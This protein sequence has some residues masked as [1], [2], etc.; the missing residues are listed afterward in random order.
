MDEAGNDEAFD[1]L[2]DRGEL[3]AVLGRQWRQRGGNVLGG[4][5]GC[6]ALLLDRRAV[7]G[8]PAGDAMHPEAGLI[9]R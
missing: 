7:V 5:I 8:D 2:E 6:D 9:G 3:L 1:V 4:D